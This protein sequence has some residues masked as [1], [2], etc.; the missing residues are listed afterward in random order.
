MD[1]DDD[2]AVWLVS[3]AAV[4]DKLRKMQGN[5]KERGLFIKEPKGCKIIFK[6]KVKLHFM[7][8]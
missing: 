6:V 8:S 2:K 1:D 3:L 5:F 7:T 4:A